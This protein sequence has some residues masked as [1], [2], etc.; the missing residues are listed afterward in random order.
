MELDENKCAAIF[1]SAY[2]PILELSAI[3]LRN[4]DMHHI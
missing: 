4:I 3:G 2:K 1:G